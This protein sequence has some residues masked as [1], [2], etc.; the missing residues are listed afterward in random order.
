MRSGWWERA[1]R[2]SLGKRDML[3]NAACPEMRVDP[4]TFRVYVDGELATCAPASE[5]PLTQRYLLR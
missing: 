3:H 5:L 4:E 2:G 1:A